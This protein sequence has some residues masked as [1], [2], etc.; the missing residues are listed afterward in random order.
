MT[1]DTRHALCHSLRRYHKR[2]FEYF[3]ELGFGTVGVGVGGFMGYVSLLLEGVCGVSKDD[4]V[5]RFSSAQE[6]PALQRS[7]RFLCFLCIKQARLAN[8]ST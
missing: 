6:D 3:G 7:G 5:N 1:T 8:L 2:S 4:S